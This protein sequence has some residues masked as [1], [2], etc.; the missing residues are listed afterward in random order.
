MRKKAIIM[1]TGGKAV[2]VFYTCY[3]NRPEF[4]VVGFTSLE[5]TDEAMAFGSGMTGPLY[6]HGIPI[7][8]ERR[9]CELVRQAR[10]REVVFARTQVSFDDLNRWEQTIVFEA[11]CEF[12]FAQVERCMLPVTK[13]AIAVCGTASG[14]GKTRVARELAQI[15][16]A[17]GKR[18]A[19]CRYPTADRAVLERPWQQCVVDE[20]SASAESAGH[21]GIPIVVYSGGDWGEILKEAQANADLLIWDGGSNDIPFIAPN[22]HITV[23]DALNDGLAELYP[24]YVNLELCQAVLLNRAERATADR[25]A[26]IAA[27]VKRINPEVR[28]F[29]SLADLCVSDWYQTF[30]KTCLERMSRGGHRQN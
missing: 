11:D 1:G 5:V 22:L 7:W 21:S 13:A 29:Q 10:V 18:V 26:P 6:P 16:Q 25:I 8:P 15:W 30:A 12:Q 20:S 14:C 3:R 24:G 17:Q 28:V 27:V 19:L 2:H 4:E 9:L 23:I